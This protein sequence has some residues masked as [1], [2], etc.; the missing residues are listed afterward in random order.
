[1]DGT[2][3]IKIFLPELAKPNVRICGNEEIRLVVNVIV[4]IGREILNRI[5]NGCEKQSGECRLPVCRVFLISIMMQ[6]R[7][8]IPA[9][10][11]RCTFNGQWHLE[12]FRQYGDRMENREVRDGQ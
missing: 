4:R 7:I 1:M 6:E 2:M 5:M 11:T 12:A 10:M 9:R 8:E 3:R